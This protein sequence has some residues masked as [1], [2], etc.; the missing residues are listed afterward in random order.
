MFMRQV[1]DFAIATDCNEIANALINDINKH[2]HLP[3]HILGE[4]TRY[5]GMDIKQTRHYVKIHC[6]KYITKLKQSYPW[7]EHEQKP[8]DLPL[9]FPSNAASLSKLIHQDHSELTD[10]QRQE[11]EM[12][13]GVKFR[14]AM[15]EIMFPMIKCRP[16]ISPHAIILS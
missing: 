16:D 6:N 1:D 3:I 8:S 5:N 10:I 15:G 12:K 14:Q 4:V 7:L 9:P 2:L 13:M 11:M